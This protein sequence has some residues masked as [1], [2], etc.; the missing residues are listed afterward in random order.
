MRDNLCHECLEEVE[1][2]GDAVWWCKEAKE[3]WKFISF[4]SLICSFKGLG[5]FDV[6]LGL[7]GLISRNDL[8]AVCVIL[9]GIWSNTNAFVHS[10]K[11]R[12]GEELVTWDMELL[13]KY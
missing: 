9:W 7:N 5:G 10:R 12:A 8:E 2:V 4:W 3:V 1:T 13:K 6:L 11:W